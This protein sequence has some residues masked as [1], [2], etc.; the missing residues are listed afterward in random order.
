M[1][2]GIEETKSDSSL[3]S[4]DLKVSGDEKVLDELNS[5]LSSSEFA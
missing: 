5:S 2:P 4:E 1:E 3:D